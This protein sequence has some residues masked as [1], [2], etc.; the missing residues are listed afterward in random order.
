MID[1]YESE[2]VEHMQHFRASADAAL[3]SLREELE[4]AHAGSLQDQETRMLEE[5]NTAVERAKQLVNEQYD[6]INADL[7]TK[8]KEELQVAT[9][10]MEIQA[11]LQVKEVRA[12]AA[13]RAG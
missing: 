5:R 13:R 11:K 2:K 8:H 3:Q 6:H 10:D 9:E 12:M 7:R 1:A 4:A